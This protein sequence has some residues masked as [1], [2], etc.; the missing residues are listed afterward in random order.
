M[1]NQPWVGLSWEGFAIDQILNSLDSQGRQ[2]EAYFFRTSD[3]YELDLVVILDNR[4]WAFE[5][6]L[7]GSPGN[8]DMNR[9]IKTSEMI[10]ADRIALITRTKTE[11][12]SKNTIS[13]NL[14]GIMKLL[15]D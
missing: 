15:S 8:E 2:Y 9:L 13:T 1:L 11:I 7:T 5:I 6:K 3:G 12:K 14:A 4:K 10:N